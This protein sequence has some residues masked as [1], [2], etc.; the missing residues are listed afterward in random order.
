MLSRA[1]VSLELVVYLSQ[2]LATPCFDTTN[3]YRT[4]LTGIPMCANARN[5]RTR[6]FIL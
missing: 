6:R 5:G 1:V 2:I 4:H 3:N